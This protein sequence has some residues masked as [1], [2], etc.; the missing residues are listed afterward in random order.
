MIPPTSPGAA[1]YAPG[2]P[3][4]PSPAPPT[5]SPGSATSSSPPDFPPYGQARPH[6]DKSPT[7][8]GPATPSPHNS[9]TRVLRTE[10]K[11]KGPAMTSQIPD[12]MPQ[13]GPLEQAAPPASDGARRCKQPGCGAGLPAATG[14][15]APRVFCSPACSRKWHNDSRVS[16]SPP[17][18]AQQAAVAA[19]PLAG[20]HQLLTQAAG[21]VAGA[22]AQAAGAVQAEQAATA[23]MHAA[24][25]DTQAA[26]EAADQARADADAADAR[27]QAAAGH[28]SVQ[29][30]EI[31]REAAAASAD[32]DAALATADQ[33]RHRADTEISR[34]RQ[35]EADA[36]AEN[37][38]VRADAARERDAAAAACAVQL[39]AIQ[40]LADT[41]RA[42][43]EHAEQQLDLERDRQRRLT[44]QPPADGDPGDGAPAAPAIIRPGAKATRTTTGAGQP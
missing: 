18:A 26:L 3:P 13:P 16:A 25:H 31:R 24:R 20:L 10:K 38:R 35:A 19:G 39:H 28:A 2:T 37:D 5:C 12:Q 1:C 44:A 21:L 27:A 40:A 17:A 9:E 6:P 22:L 11:K 4:R 32:R 34:A 23:A 30:A 15:G 43:A 7:T 36:R 8:P 42:R 14:R 29:V 41:W 33:A